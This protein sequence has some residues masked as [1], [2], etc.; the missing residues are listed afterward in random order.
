MN[1]QNFNKFFQDKD[2]EGIKA[3]F[4]E[5]G[6]VSFDQLQFALQHQQLDEAKEIIKQNEMPIPNK[7]ESEVRLFIQQER[8]K[9]TK[10]RKIRRMVKRKFGII[11]IS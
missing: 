8:S 5:S 1:T 7:L 4:P 6:Q 11:V 10:E 3:M 2:E 9:N